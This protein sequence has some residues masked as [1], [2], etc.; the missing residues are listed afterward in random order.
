MDT[1]PNIEKHGLSLD[2]DSEIE[3][4]DHTEEEEE[5]A[6][7]CD[8]EAILGGFNSNFEWSVKL[9][10]R[11]G[12]KTIIKNTNF[13]LRVPSGPEYEKTRKIC[14]QKGIKYS[15]KFIQKCVIAPKMDLNTIEILPDPLKI[16]IMNAIATRCG[17]TKDTEDLAENFL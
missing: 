9:P 13:V 17:Y 15:N 3:V 10:H 4:D 7:I 12:K 2:P 14:K 1:G 11:I 5:E 8:V 6:Q 16:L